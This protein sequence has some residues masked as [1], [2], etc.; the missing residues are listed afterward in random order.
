MSNFVTSMSLMIGEFYKNFRCV[1]VSA[2]TGKGMDQLFEAIS[3]AAIDYNNVCRFV[4]FDVIVWFVLLLLFVCL[5]VVVVFFFLKI[6]VCFLF[7]FNFAYDVKSILIER[8][9]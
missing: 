6:L 1:G 3:E 8:D 4:L 2:V 7:Y 9:I 5:F